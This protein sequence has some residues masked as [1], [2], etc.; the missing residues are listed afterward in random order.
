L[1]GTKAGTGAN[2]N[3]SQ[4]LDTSTLA[5]GAHNLL[6]RGYD[7]AGNSSY[8][9]SGV[10]VT[11][12][13]ANPGILSWAKDAGVSPLNGE[14]QCSS[15][16]TDSQGNQIM[17][18]KFSGT[19]NFAG[20][21]LISQGG[22]DFY[23]AKFN[24]AGALSWIKTFGG[25][26]DNVANSV[27]VDGVDNILVTGYFVGSMN[28]GGTTL[29]SGGG[30]TSPDMFLAK[31]NS[32]GTLSWA[33]RFG[34]A[35]GN[36]ANGVAVDKNNDVFVTGQFNVSVDFGGGTVTSFGSTDGFVAKYSGTTGAYVWARGFG[37][38]GYDI[39]EGVGIDGNG[40]VFVSG[41]S[42]GSMD[43]GGGVRPS[44]GGSDG[45]MAKLSGVNGNH[46][47]SQMIGGPGNESTDG[48]AIDATGNGIFVG[49][50]TGTMTVGGQTFSA[51]LSTAM[52]IGR[53][54]ASGNVAWARAIGGV[55]SIGGSVGPR[56]VAVDSAGNVAITGVVTGEADF[57]SGQ[58]G[59]GTGNIF[60]AKY[61]S[62]GG[63]LWDKRFSSTG[64]S[65]GLG[66]AIDSSRN[67]I[68]AG[69]FAGT[70]NFDTVQL[71]TISPQIKDAYLVKIS[72]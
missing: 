70:I 44:N 1:A 46:I 51:P 13:N 16:K 2:A 4:S 30:T 63:Y 7:A 62:T 31:L 66:L 20:T 72:P 37:G 69:S 47:W 23:V 68:G 55:S 43:F 3:Y 21:T 49:S 34:G 50:F 60:I 11:N 18:G 10:T 38:T 40:E 71:T 19:V 29:V 14:A 27:A 45:F 5:N 52:L 61:N 58:I 8:S 12:Y 35:F 22:Y 39:S 25:T 42:T 59:S 67:I 53:F 17:V 33:K 41:Y 28:L 57:G 15:V 32:A 65:A 56:A 9:I 64:W 48:V 54:D 24:S 26:Y 36:Y 6:V